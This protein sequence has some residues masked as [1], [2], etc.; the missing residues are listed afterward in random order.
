MLDINDLDRTDLRLLAELQRD[1]SLSNLELAD[2]V[3][4]SPVSYTHLTLPT[5]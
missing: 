4:L 1:A 2:K 3:G 5:N